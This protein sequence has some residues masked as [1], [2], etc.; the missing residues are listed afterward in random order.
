MSIGKVIFAGAIGLFAVIGVAGAIKKKKEAKLTETVSV[1]KQ[2]ESSLALSEERLKEIAT[3]EIVEV[4]EQAPQV[5]VAVSESIDSEY[6]PKEINRIHR[7]FTFGKSR[8]PF[9]KTIAYTSRVPWLNGRPAWIA[10]YASHYS[11]SR[12][13]IARA[14]NGKKDYFTQKVSSGD[15]FNVFD[16][17]RNIEFYSVVDLSQLKMWFYAF[18]RDA[19]ERVLLK[20]YPVG[21]GK[22]SEDSESG[23]LTPLGRYLLGD[24]IAI[25]KPGVEGFFEDQKVEM[26]QIFG[27][28]WIPFKEEIDDS[29]PFAKG[30]GI[31]G[32][33]WHQDETT[34]DLVEDSH[35][36]G[37]FDSSG[38]LRLSQHDM[39]EFFSIVITKPT[40]VDIVKSF[41]Q[42]KLP[43]K[44][45]QDPLEN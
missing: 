34:G 6:L 21:V 14:L 16:E 25:Y 42:A 35:F 26:I 12:H 38:C 36:I 30:L 44:E 22:T 11:T 31:H 7:L 43:G 1:A 45:W 32:A 28:R 13:F 39:E 33:P 20:T 8:L 9:V 29:K 41:D 27:T 15:R 40:V 19:G 23:C 2:E 17:E 24:K 10:D 37:K 18:D 3:R 4:V 5:K